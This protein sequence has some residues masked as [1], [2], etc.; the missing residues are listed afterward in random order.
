MP[1]AIFYKDDAFVPSLQLL[2]DRTGK[3]YH[4]WLDEYS[5]SQD[6][7]EPEQMDIIAEEKE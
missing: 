4:A 1:A 5:K 3:D 7:T 2:S 6:D